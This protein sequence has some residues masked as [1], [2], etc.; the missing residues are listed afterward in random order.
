MPRWLQRA[1]RQ[2]A[3]WLLV[4]HRPTEGRAQRLRPVGSVHR[5]ILLRLAEI[6]AQRIV[7]AVEA[8]DAPLYHRRVGETGAVHHA[9]RDRLALRVANLI[10]L[11]DPFFVAL[12]QQLRRPAGR[13]YLLPDV[14]DSPRLRFRLIPLCGVAE[15]RV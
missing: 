5:R 8:F 6:V 14:L 12:L 7:S 13:L 10:H 4:L 2:T 9:V 15:E 1:W 3:G 11:R